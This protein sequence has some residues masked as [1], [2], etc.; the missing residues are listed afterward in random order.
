MQSIP[1]KYLVPI[2]MLLGIGSF[3]FLQRPAHVCD[4]QAE[5]FRASTAGL[6]YP[7]KVKQSSVPPTFM[8]HV[9]SCKIGNSPGACFELF[10]SLR[11]VI[12]E[13]TSTSVDCWEYFGE[14][15]EVHNAVEQGLSLM[16]RIAWGGSPP[17]KNLQK[18]GWLETSDMALFC[19]MKQA[20][21][22]MYGQE[23]YDQFRSKVSLL[24]PGESPVYDN[25]SKCLNCEYLKS[26][27]KTLSAEEI[28][29][30]SLF[31]VRCDQYR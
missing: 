19:S 14:I 25:Q 27:D 3:F 5:V 17:E 10:T 1:Q 30:R 11:Q 28:W 31:S 20:Y 7:K 18:L 9:E 24:L 22:E 6:L 15:K 16:V 23:K 4:S 29:L 13:L 21:L 8:K 12:R 26:A 2:L